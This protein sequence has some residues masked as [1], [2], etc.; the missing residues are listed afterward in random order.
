MLIKLL[1]VARTR[2]ALRK[3]LRSLDPSIV[4]CL[5]DIGS[6][7]GPKGR[8]RL[9]PGRVHTVGFDPRE[10]CATDEPGHTVV[11]CAVG[12]NEDVVDF[13][14]T[15]TGNMSSTLPP[16]TEVLYRFQDRACKMEVMRAER[17]SV[18]PL[19]T[20]AADIAADAIKVDV[21]G[22]EL[23][24]LAGAERVL[25]SGILLAEIEVSFI[26]RY[27]GQ[28]LADEVICFMRQRGF[29]LIDLYQVRR[30]YRTNARRVRKFAIIKDSRSGQLAYADAVFF[31]SDVRFQAMVTKLRSRERSI[32]I[33]K[34]ILLLTVYGKFDRALQLF[35]EYA[36]ALDPF[37]REALNPFVATFP[38]SRKRSSAERRP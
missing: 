36:T 14:V 33:V 20:V 16:N 19:D 26:E 15:H 21:Q 38:T 25:Q 27:R 4:I 23:D 22:A 2:L 7:G 37:M 34:A 13:Y 17:L 18:A 11:P 35:E 5:L 29:D 6:I 3:F 12:R 30:Y 32:L 8:W 31:V 28:P 10:Q 1:A 9:I 24:V